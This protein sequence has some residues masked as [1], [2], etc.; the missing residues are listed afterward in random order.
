MAVVPAK[1]TVAPSRALLAAKPDFWGPRW[2]VRSSSLTL[3]IGC[4]NFVR[5]FSRRLPSVLGAVRVSPPP[6]VH[7]VFAMGHQGLGAPL[8]GGGSRRWAA[9]AVDYA[10]HSLSIFF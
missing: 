9:T 2:S 10:L 8:L 6:P 4:R 5:A 7:A 3:R 1:L